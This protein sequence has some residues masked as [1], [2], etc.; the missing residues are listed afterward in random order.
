[1]NCLLETVASLWILSLRATGTKPPQEDNVCIHENLESCR[2]TL[3]SRESNLEETCKKLSREALARR[4]QGDIT[5]AKNKLLERRRATKRLER[6]RSSLSLVDAQLD[7]LR[8]TELDREVMQTLLASSAA[9]KK[10]GVGKGVKEAEAI[11]S[12]LD[13]Q[14]RDSSELTSVLSGSLM[15][16]DFDL[17][18]EL[19][20]LQQDFEVETALGVVASSKSAS[21]QHPVQVNN[22]EY[23]VRVEEPKA[24]LEN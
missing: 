4:Q 15:E 16:S 9:L 14:M 11:M 8:T 18:A 22:Q 17:D 20:Q 5:G 19:E 12:D 1:M 3:E 21:I 13:E 2:E 10:A 23:I 24:A 6:L 7:A